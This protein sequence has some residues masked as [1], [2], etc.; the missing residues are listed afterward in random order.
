M[1]PS[2]E[3]A[4]FTDDG[5][6]SL[7][8]RCGLAPIVIRRRNDRVIGGSLLSA[9]YALKYT[10]VNAGNQE[11]VDQHETQKKAF[12]EKWRKKYPLPGGL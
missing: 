3:A 12:L 7:C 5:S 10:K 11:Q 6:S 4:P 9:R 8:I 1:L 2:V